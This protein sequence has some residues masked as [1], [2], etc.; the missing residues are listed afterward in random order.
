[1][2][3]LNIPHMLIYLH[4]HLTH[5]P[6]SIPCDATSPPRPFAVALATLLLVLF[7][8]PVAAQAR[9]TTVDD[10]LRR[11]R[12]GQIKRTRFVRCWG[13]AHDFSSPAN[14][15]HLWG[16]VGA[17]FDAHPRDAPAR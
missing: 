17:W 7:A 1:V 6:P 15:R 16:E 11:E 10:L 14:I 13:E 4:I 8:S 3:V 12:L 2:H 9:S 5:S